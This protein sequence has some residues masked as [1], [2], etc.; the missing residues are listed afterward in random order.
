MVAQKI[1]VTLS[2]PIPEPAFL[3]T[4]VRR[5]SEN[6]FG[7]AG[8]ISIYLYLLTTVMDSFYF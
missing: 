1:E 3:C 4:L 8:I 6:K 5:Y 7:I 2:P